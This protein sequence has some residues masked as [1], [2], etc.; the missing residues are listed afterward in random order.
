MLM[1][2]LTIFC[3]TMSNLPWFMNLTF[4]VPMQYCS[5]QQWILCSSPD[6]STTEYLF[7][8]GPAPSSFLGL[9]VVVLCSFPV[10]CWTPSNLR[11]S[12]FSVITF[13]LFIQ[14]LRFSRQ[15]YWGG[16]P[17]PPPVDHILSELSTMTHLSWVALHGIAHS[18][19]ELHRPLSHDKAVIC[20]G[21]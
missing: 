3:L 1:F 6:K 11:D 21:D 12:S 13:W 15:V 17:S 18:F 20:E 8:F 16:L 5:L 10:A 2:I 7:C 19:V 4:E 14:F 9:L